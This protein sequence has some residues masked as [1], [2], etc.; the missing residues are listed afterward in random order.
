MDTFT[1]PP[2]DPLNQAKCVADPAIKEVIDL[3]AG[4]VL[5]SAEFIERYR[6]A[7]LIET[8]VE[9]RSRMSGD[10]PRVICAICEVPVHII[11]RTDRSAFHF[12][13]KEEDGSCP[14]QTRSPLSEEQIRARK[15]HGLRESEPHK[16]IK[17]LVLRS[18][19]ADPAFRNT[20]PEQKWKSRDDPKRY[21]RPDVQSE[22][23][24]GK[25]AFEIQL[26]TTF[27]GVVVGRRDFYRDEGAL[28]VWVM[29]NF[30]PAYRLMTTDDLLFSNKSNIVVVDEETTALSERTRQ[31]HV[32]CHF[33]KPVRNGD[34]I[35]DIWTSEVVQFAELHQ[36]RERQQAYFFDYDAAYD[37]LVS[38]IAAERQAA[39]DAEIAEDADALF[40]FW[41]I[42]GHRFRHTAENRAYWQ[43]IRERFEKWEFDLPEWPD[44]DLEFEAMLSV[45]CSVREGK[46]VG[47]KFSSLIQVAHQVAESHPRLLVAFGHAVNIYERATLLKEQDTKGKWNDKL[48]GKNGAEGI[49]TR[50][51]RRDETLAPNPELLPL[52]TFLFPKVGAKV[53]AYIDKS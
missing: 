17:A 5:G 9:I 39:L 31:F 45:L 51:K 20:V 35:S 48:V 2:I 15:Y 32:R 34:E 30:D 4:Q 43:D 7:E 23:D 26:S 38:T 46:P 12:R 53:R 18:L 52:L 11:L 49:S 22:N 25:F 14:A 40:E 42:H 33:R 19:D 44:I 6:N 8:R 28:L 21:R 24:S 10:Q 16:K 41:K 13:H 50:M 36:D 3:D 47:Y 29:G 37:T 27:L 1:P